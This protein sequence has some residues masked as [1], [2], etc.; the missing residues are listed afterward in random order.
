MAKKHMEKVLTIPGHKV[1]E[2][3]NHTKIPHHPCLNGYHQ[4]HHHQQM[5][6]RMWGKSNPDTLL[7][8]M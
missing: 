8:G 7:V 4:D 2:N 1:N 5:L 3:Q 6:A